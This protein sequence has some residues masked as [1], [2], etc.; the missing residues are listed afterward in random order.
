M[1]VTFMEIHAHRFLGKVNTAQGSFFIM[2][3]HVDAVID[4]FIRSAVEY[5]CSMSRITDK[6]F[7]MPT[8]ICMFYMYD[9]CC[10]RLVM[11]SRLRQTKFSLHYRLIRK[12]LNL[13][14][15]K[16]RV[17]FYKA[18]RIGKQIIFRFINLK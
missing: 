11:S 15:N 6:Y 9:I 16:H 13:D 10:P 4:G 2:S 8:Q 3:L 7:W 17:V 14:K 1:P 18:E 12:V 5:K